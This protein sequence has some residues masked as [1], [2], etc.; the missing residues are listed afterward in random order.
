M[1]VVVVVTHF[2]RGFDSRESEEE[3]AEMKAV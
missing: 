3:S 2:A 1:V